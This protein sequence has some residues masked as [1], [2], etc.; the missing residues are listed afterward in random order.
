MTT[1]ESETPSR[2]AGG[3]VAAAGALAALAAV[4]ALAPEA[5]ALTV[6]A[7]GGSAL[8]WATRRPMPDS[9]ATPPP[10]SDTPTGDVYAGE[11]EN[12][13]RVVR[14]PGEGMWIIHPVRQEVPR[15]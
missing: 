6:W 3:C 8:W 2:A 9:S 11:T 12:I 14:G 10:P 13:D 4:F 15:P 5:G 7:V 1:E